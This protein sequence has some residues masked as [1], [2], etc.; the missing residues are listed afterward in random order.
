MKG[1][2][3]IKMKKRKSTYA[4]EIPFLTFNVVGP[5]HGKKNCLKGLAGDKV[6]KR[7]LSTKRLLTKK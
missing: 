2:K 6:S 7:T 4:L 3:T 5:D 1:T